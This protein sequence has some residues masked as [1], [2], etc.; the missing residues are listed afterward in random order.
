MAEWRPP[1]GMMITSERTHKKLYPI[2][3]KR[4]QGTAL[5]AGSNPAIPAK[6]KGIMKKPLTAQQLADKIIKEWTQ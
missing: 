6:E 3:Y 4:S 1:A 5:F 2:E